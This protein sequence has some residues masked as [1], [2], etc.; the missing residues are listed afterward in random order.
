MGSEITLCSN[1]FP[2][3]IPEGPLYEYTVEISAARNLSRRLKRC[4][5]QLAEQTTAWQQAGLVGNVAHDLNSSK[6][7]SRRILPHPLTITI[8]YYD[9]DQ[10]GPPTAGGME[11]TL[12]ITF[13]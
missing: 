6:L 4:I 13:V 3:G 7:V 2:V 1:Y 8:P 10:Q 5:Y 11:Y 12:T 9:E